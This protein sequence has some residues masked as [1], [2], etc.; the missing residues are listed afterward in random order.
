MGI[1]DFIFVG[2]L[3]GFENFKIE[4]KNK[5][6]NNRKNRH[7]AITFCIDSK[8]C[9]RRS[10]LSTPCHIDINEHLK[11]IKLKPLQLKLKRWLVKGVKLSPIRRSHKT[12]VLLIRSLLLVALIDSPHMTIQP[13]SLR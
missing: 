5:I 7:F 12:L 9:I 8:S 11:Q 3:R 1:I 10:I 13:I 6:K 4:L 2:E